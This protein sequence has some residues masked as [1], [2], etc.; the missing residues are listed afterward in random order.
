MTWPSFLDVERL[1]WL[2]TAWW[3]SPI[4]S[5]CLLSDSQQMEHLGI[6]DEHRSKGITVPYLGI[7]PR[8][9]GQGLI[10]FPERH[11][12]QSSEL[13]DFSKRSFLP[14]E[15]EDPS[16][17]TPEF[18]QS[19]FQ[20][21]LWFGMLDEFARACGLHIDLDSF[22]Q[23]GA[24]GQ[25]VVTT[26]ALLPYVRSVAI[27]QLVQRDV[28]LDLKVGDWVRLRE[29]PNVVSIASDHAR[30]D[31]DTPDDTPFKPASPTASGRAILLN[32]SSKTD[33][34]RPGVS[35]LGT[36]THTHDISL[37]SRQVTKCLGNLRYTF[38]DND[39]EEDVWNSTLL[40]RV[41]RTGNFADLPTLHPKLEDV[42]LKRIISLIMSSE[43]Y[44][45]PRI[46]DRF[47]RF[48]NCLQEARKSMRSTLMHEDTL[49]QLEVAFSIDILCDS[50]IYVMLNIFGESMNVRAPYFGYYMRNFGDRMKANNWCL[51]R[52]TS[53]L[54][55][56]TVALY[57]KSVLPSYELTPHMECESIFCSRQSHDVNSLHA[58]HDVNTCD[59]L[60]QLLFVDEQELVHIL[61]SDGIPGISCVMKEGGALNYEV[62][63]ITGRD[64]I[65][66]SHVWSH[67]LGN[68]SQNALPIC[69]VIRLFNL[70]RHIS[71]PNVL[72]WI[73][74][75]SVPV[76][77]KYKRIAI[78]RLRTVYQEAQGVLVID[79]HLACVGKDTQERQ[80]QLLSSE[81]MR[82]LWTLQEG[83]LA[84]RLYVQFRH[85]AVPV[86]QLSDNNDFPADN[87][88]FGDTGG[89]ASLA[90]RL[91]FYQQ[92]RLTR[93]LM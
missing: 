36:D 48:E 65:A 81:W 25:R 38:D 7:A 92:H 61:S 26:E 75:L 2:F 66:I 22:I 17:F 72:L 11:G 37:V 83:R 82:R 50:L 55:Y 20:E 54:P 27:D 35:S 70:I 53:V 59:G 64:Y 23:T 21:W 15:N 47:S 44:A 29:R 74:T 78:T 58:Q 46:K 80:V 49:L 73:D 24:G 43:A 51:A 13:S 67:G 41:G 30:P 34:I 63:D 42:S 6:P 10:G 33:A 5:T 12:F 76:N 85:E 79:R 32:M 90:I 68:P 56:D 19:L 3:S 18:V 71:S 87:F 86:E 14:V 91:H 31:E 57:F 84:T 89:P 28:P 40:A 69:Q 60:C 88:V 1:Q 8:Y 9:D 52:T 93:R 4:E 39:E 77:L 62:V 16:P 45:K